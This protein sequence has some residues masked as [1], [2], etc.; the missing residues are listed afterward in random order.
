MSD[1]LTKRRPQ[2][3]ST[4]N[5]S[6][7][8]EIDYWTKTLHTTEAKLRIAVSKVGTYVSDVKEYLQNH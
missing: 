4:I 8:W 1:D 7:Q 5:L 2:D 6:Q 3:A